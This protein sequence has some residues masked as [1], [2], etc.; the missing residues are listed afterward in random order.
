MTVASATA[1]TP[2]SLLS[3][4]PESDN[5]TR[6]IDSQTVG[7]NGKVFEFDRVFDPSSTQKEVYAAVAPFVQ[8]VVDGFSTSIIAYGQTGAG[9]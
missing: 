7:L 5:Q 1:A 4:N 3:L 6:L 8:S 2:A 9:Q